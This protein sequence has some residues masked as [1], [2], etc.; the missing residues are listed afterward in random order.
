M[1]VCKGQEIHQF[2]IVGQRHKMEHYPEF[3]N[4]DSIEIAWLH[5]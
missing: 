5:D 3:K 1:K 4:W 2:R